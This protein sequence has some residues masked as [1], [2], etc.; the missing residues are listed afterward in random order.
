MTKY[1]HPSVF[2]KELTDDKLNYV[3]KL[4]LQVFDSSLRDINDKFDDNYT[5]STNYFK[6][7]LNC[8]SF[9]FN[10]E[11]CPYKIEISNSSN[12]FIFQIGET[13]CRFFEEKDYFNP[14]KKGAF[15]RDVQPQPSLFN[16]DIGLPIFSNFYLMYSTDED[17]NALPTVV[18][19]SYDINKNIV[20][21][22]EYNSSSSSPSIPSDDL[23]TPDN[24]SP[25]RT[26]NLSSKRKK[27]DRSDEN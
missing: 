21:F 2:D 23:Y 7:T 19:V 24:H 14:T 13:L 9:E 12:K 8:L 25:K 27:A 5:F 20:S 3:S 15:V 22:W 4:M 6:R 17:G 10:S 26:R 16:E 18:F 11:S 1:S